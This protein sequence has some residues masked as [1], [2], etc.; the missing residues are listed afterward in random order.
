M[1]SLKI[2]LKNKPKKELYNAYHKSANGK[3]LCKSSNTPFE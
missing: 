1:I 3:K 2:G